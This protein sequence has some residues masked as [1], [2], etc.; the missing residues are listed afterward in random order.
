MCGING[1]TWA[2]E[3]LLRVMNDRTKNRGPDDAGVLVDENVSLGHRRLSIIDL[4]A[5]GHQP[6][7]NMD[8]TVWI[9]YNG[10]VYNF[11]EIRKGLEEKGH[12]FKSHTDTEVIL[13]SYELLG[14]DCFDKFN[15]MWAFCI[16]DKRNEQILLCRDRYGI[17]PLYYHIDEKGLI[18][19]SMISAILVHNVRTGPNEKAIMEYLALGLEQ[20]NEETFFEN[21]YSLDPGSFIRWDL[22][23]KKYEIKKWYFPKVR[24]DNSEDAVREA[25]TESV[26]LQ[27]VADVPIGS[28]LSGGL[29]SSAIVC[30]LDRFLEYPFYTFSFTAP[31]TVFD[32]TKY[33]ME[34]GKK[35]KTRQF[36]T[37]LSVDDFL[38]DIE[39]FVV[40]LE[41]PVLSL[42]PYAQYRVMKLAHDNGVKVLLDG[43]GGDEIFAGYPYYFTY[44]YWGL[45]KQLQM[46]RLIREIIL[47]VHNFKNVHPVKLFGFLMF[48]EIVKKIIYRKFLNNWINPELL[49]KFCGDRI[50]PEWKRMSLEDALSMSLFSTSIP[51]LLLWEDKNSMRWSVE[52]RVPF[53]D[54]N[55]VETVLSQPPEAK[56]WDGRTKVTYK[57]AV[58]DILPP[59]IL[60]RKDKI[61]F[62][63]PAADLLREPKIADYCR[64]LIFS[65]SFKKRPYWKWDKIV[66]KYN[67]HVEGKKNNVGVLWKCLNLEIWLRAFHK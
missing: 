35:T 23:T 33:I 11:R 22:K 62:K 64:G 61:G 16:Y 51:R 47:Y 9:V 31:N 55:L 53:L 30:L 52:S 19:S 50:A 26:R 4:S 39:D 5:N 54:V 24:N 40:T 29:D 42:S 6:M 37:R 2:D 58:K 38:A 49:G 46:Y 10:E 25:F 45:L 44:H 14:T 1:F 41:E 8:D 13:R 17:K 15:G 20:Y 65:E 7:S 56:L 57:R 18:F 66:D 60:N 12:K 27:T 34:V 43:Q 59:M 67:Q 36:F 63:A 21:I 28:C 3:K 32:E 48:P